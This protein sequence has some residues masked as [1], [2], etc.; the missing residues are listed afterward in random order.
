MKIEWINRYSDTEFPDNHERW[1]RLMY[2]NKIIFANISQFRIAKTL[3][4]EANLKFPTQQNDTI[5]NFKSFKS[6]KAAKTWC[7]KEFLKFQKKLQYD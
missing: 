3:F 5:F 7:E 4:Y 1:K 2:I 6:E